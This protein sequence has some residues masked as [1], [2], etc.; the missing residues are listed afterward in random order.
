LVNNEKKSRGY[1]DD[2]IAALKAASERG[3]IGG[4][5]H[6]FGSR[7]MPIIV[8][9]GGVAAGSVP[10]AITAAAAMH[11]ISTALRAGASGIAEGRLSRARELVGSG[12][13]PYPRNQLGP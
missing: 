13:P 8:G 11:G 10:E 7:L 9:A 1:S 3:V 4:A 6:V 5:L 12:V 2:E